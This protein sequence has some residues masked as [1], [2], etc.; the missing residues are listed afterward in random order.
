MMKKSLLIILSINLFLMACTVTENAI[1]PV[2]IHQEFV[3]FEFSQKSP[4]TV[5]KLNGYVYQTVSQKNV[6]FESCK[7][8]V[9]FDVA[10]IAEF[11]YFRFNLLLLS[12]EAFNKYSGAVVSKVS[13]FPA[14]FK[15]E[16]FSE[17]P[18]EVAPLLN[19]SDKVQRMNKTLLDY[20]K[21][22]EVMMEAKHRSKLLTKEDEIYITLLARG[23]FDGDGFE[24]LLV[25]S[26]WFARNASGKYADLLI[27]SKTHDDE[28]V[29]IQWRLKSIK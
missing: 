3:G 24:D 2:L 7:Q 29:S 21:N 14:E 15:P 1:E 4:I 6:S 26:E 13:Y 12:C 11:E 27:L 8:A 23:D 18:A 5:I 25:K 16:F 20:D 22:T 9:E 19:S 17:L 10:Q 28:P